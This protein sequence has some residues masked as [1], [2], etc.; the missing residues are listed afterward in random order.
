[1]AVDIVKTETCNAPL[2][3]AFAYV[4]DYRKIPD[5][6]FGVHAFEPVGPHDYGLGSVFDV[7]VHLGLRIHTRIEAVEWE[8]NRLIGMD[9]VK[10]FKVRSR[11]YFTALDEDRT[12]VTAKVSYELPFGPAGKAMG[13]VMEPVVKQAVKHA[14]HHLVTNIE[15]LRP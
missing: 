1:M 2:K 8:E 7:T 12:E 11:W 5:W 14:S 4:A 13:K 15:A 6:M 10:G 3:T 9:S